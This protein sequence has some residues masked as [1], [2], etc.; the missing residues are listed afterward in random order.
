MRRLFPEN[1]FVSHKPGTGLR[2]V[3][4]EAPGEDEQLQ[5]EPLVGG[6]GKWFNALIAKAR[7]RR[8]E[9]TLANVIQCRPPENMFPTDGKARCYISQTE[10]HESVRHCI[11]E[12]VEPLLRSR[13]WQRIDVLGEKP[14]RFLLGKEEG[15]FKWRGS[16]LPVP[17]IDPDRPL[18]VPTLHPAYVMRDQD[19]IPVVINDLL[20]GLTPP[21]ERYNLM[22]SLADV[23]AFTAKEFA[24]DIETMYW[25]LGSPQI[26]M[27]GLA[28]RPYEAI[29][30]PFQGAYIPE[31]KRIFKEATSVVGHNLVQFDLPILNKAE[32]RIRP[33]CQV[34]DTM[35]MHHLLFPNLGGD[36][37]GAG[38]HDLEFVGTCLT[39]KPAW[40]ADKQNFELYCARDT[41]VTLQAW[42][43]LLPMLRQRNLQR[44]YELVQVPLARVCHLMQETG[45]KVDTR[46]IGEVREKLAEEMAK[47]ERD[48]PAMLRTQDVEV[49]KRQPAPPGT[50]SEKTGKPLKF[51]MV[52][53]TKKVVPW[54]SPAKK[55]QFLYGP[56]SKGG[57]ELPPQLDPKTQ[58][59]STD[60]I[61]LEKLYRRTKNP[62][63]LAIR[64]LNK[65]DELVT[66]FAKE[67]MTKISRMHPHFNVHG[68][69][70]GRL[71]SSDPN[72]QN[73]PKSSRVIYVPSAP[74]WK[75][76]DVDYS[77]IEN[78]LT[79]HFAGDTERMGRF[80]RDP[81]FSEHK[82]AAGLFFDIPYDDVI[83]DND[84]DAPYG[85]AKRIVHGTNYGMGAKKIANMYDMDYREVR[86]LQNRWK[87]AILETS[88]W[89]NQTA[90]LAK[91]QGFLVT[92]F[93]RRRD[94]YTSSAY[95]ES[96]SF[97]PQS[98]AAD[99]IFR[100]M[101]GLMYE[102]VGWPLEKVLKVVRVAKPLPQPA[103]LLL[104]VHDSLVFECPA[105]MVDELVA[106]VREVMEQPWPELG[107]LSVP[108]GVEVGD[109]WGEVE[110]YT[111]AQT[112]KEAA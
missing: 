7:L 5:G 21:P 18:A 93:G 51:V 80:L 110:D 1:T 30:V 84:K 47:L 13:P 27:V 48:L 89:Q 54:R 105:W 107:G 29:V 25:G 32:V 53:T 49:R 65:L 81:K 92:P 20:K 101:L 56:E 16:P 12:H 38:G 55:Q 17:A 73:V 39:N 111:G 8:D 24:F 79:A 63:I 75:I 46:R 41:D 94:F 45:F 19:V 35:L 69:A 22:P 31:L 85:K 83:K 61:A 43:Q 14:L 9:L 28:A 96:L 78:R 76:V 77:Q 109:S 33:E 58:K 106:T 59:I 66:T 100:A 104:Q 42:K 99:V 26:K 71:S 70:S 108:I 50:L 57:L 95:T 74:D 90:E 88:R 37:T 68:T 60:K 97:L 34:W 6:A 67:E 2:L 3:I 72:L 112:L 64:L 102:R 15:I 23:R 44:L 82:F 40:K 11:K 36:N 10:A 52:P 86:D 62:A 87:M 98:T 4:A 91:K 103:R